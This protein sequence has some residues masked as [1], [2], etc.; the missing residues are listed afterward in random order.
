MPMEKQQSVT[1]YDNALKKA[2]DEH[3][4]SEK[5]IVIFEGCKKKA[6]PTL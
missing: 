5:I 6:C 4:E 2:K 1:F 3:Y